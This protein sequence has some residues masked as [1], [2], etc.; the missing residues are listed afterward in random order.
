M[1]NRY[2]LL[3]LLCG[4]GLAAYLLC[5]IGGFVLIG[6]HAI[7]SGSIPYGV[8]C[9][10][11]DA[12]FSPGEYVVFCLDEER[13]RAGYAAGYLGRGACPGGVSAVI[14]PIVGVA[15]DI[16][17]VTREGVCVNGKHIPAS[18]PLLH[19][20]HGERLSFYAGRHVVPL[21][22][23]WVLST[24]S[25]QS[26]DSRYYGPIQTS[27]IVTAAQKVLWVSQD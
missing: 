24:S 4:T 22:A 3:V 27:Q 2:K 6:C 19:N 18:V 7:L 16:V 17:E 9:P 1:G 23:V 20:R 8:Y 11:E 21:N 26:W 13:G 15:G 12:T 25:P 5:A 14:K 10:V